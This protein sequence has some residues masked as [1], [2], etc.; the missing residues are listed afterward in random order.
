MSSA[1]SSL[2]E[3]DH[4]LE[5]LAAL[6]ESARDGNGGLVSLEGAA[7]LGKSRLLRWTIE[8]ARSEGMLELSARGSELERDLSFGVVRQ[9]FEGWLASADPEERGK[10]LSGVAA[11]AL[12]L[13]EGRHLGPAEPARERALPAILHG[14]F[15]LVA[16]LSARRPLLLAVDDLHWSDPVSLRFLLY[17]GQRIDELPVCLVLGRR[18]QEAGGHELVAELAGHPL[19]RRLTLAPLSGAAV[20]QLLGE[21]FERE[22]GESF[23]RACLE[24]T[25]G[26][27]FLLG[28]LVSAL[29][30]DQIEPSDANAARIAGLR[31]DVVRHHA[32]VRVS[33]LGPDAVS[34]ASAATAAG[35]GVPLHHVAAVAELDVDAA[36]RAADAL[37]GAGIFSSADPPE[38]AH[39]LLRASLYEQL[40]TAQR[41]RAHVRAAQLLHGDH[42]PPEAIAEQLL[43][44]GRVGE[45]WAIQA[46]RQAAT[47]A[48]AAGNP[49]SV[50]R[51]LTRA[52]LEPLNAG[53]RAEL[54]LELARVQASVGEPG[55]EAHLIEALTLIEDPHARAR[56]HHTLG[57]VLY[58]RGE[59]GA[60][61]R[62]FE[63]ALELHGDADDALSRDL[64][65]GYFSAASL[66]PERA[67]RALEHITP[68]VG[69]PAGGET[70]AERA[71][72]A[73][74]AAHRAMTGAPRGEAIALAR[75]AWG[76]GALLAEEGP[77]G[78][79]WSLVSAA[80]SWTDEFEQ[81][82]EVCSAVI[83]QAR[84]CGSLMAYATASYCAQL[85]AHFAGRLSEARAHGEVALDA[86][87]YGWHTYVSAIAATHAGV[88]IDQGELEAAERVL[89]IIDD[90]RYAQAADRGFAV[91]ARGHLRL[92]QGR[93]GVA[94]EDFLAAGTLFE[95]IGGTNATVVPWRSGAALAAHRLGEHERARELLDA[96][97]RLA[98]TTGTPTHISRALRT[99]AQLTGGEQGIE[100]L[101]QALAALEHSQARLEQLRCLADL[102]AALRRAGQRAEA[103]QILAEA[104]QQ[105]HR[106]GARLI[107]RHVHEELRIAGAR[108]RRL[109][110]SGADALTASER[111]VAEMA[112]RGMGN[113]EIAQALF[114]T[115]RTVEQHL[116]NAYK[117]LGV[118]SRKQLPHALRDPE[119][120][121][122]SPATSVAGRPATDPEHPDPHD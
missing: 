61:A 120:T 24:A 13:F 17:L 21:A 47:Q 12:P 62:E 86:R 37:V 70:A 99:G 87:R 83:E 35:G 16:N 44:A 55:A 18:T 64:R 32:S 1:S 100:L 94:L 29:E 33:Q 38:F 15:W 68:L 122:T 72:L 81:S 48:L 39:P 97:S 77:D 58:A 76:E 105:A 80:F 78:W 115:S 98:Q 45:Q 67:L 90:A 28:A 57:N 84:A 54:L 49:E 10:A 111:R 11:L 14:L 102:G 31:P 66:D 2:L 26:N 107:E 20:A 59:L 75:R 46:L 27:P 88:L 73:G 108:P 25:G 82:L 101:R 109:S 53:E 43:P 118:Q 117:K 91:G 69:R 113:R 63:Q 50:I 112:A 7:G 52:L 96:E 95:E 56:A 30:A 119:A 6:L 40:P 60:A 51:Y 74:I 85:P 34:L 41:G 65:A 106:A 89:E 3:R 121:G 42:A 79:A 104:L 114:V 71:A 4:E 9:L 93:E 19:T 103:R 22:A 5:R 92:L 8:R 110:F 23:S 36:A 116:Y